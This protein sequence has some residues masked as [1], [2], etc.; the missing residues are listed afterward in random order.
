MARLE[1]RRTPR[2]AMLDG[3]R[4]RGAP[5]R[6]RGAGSWRERCGV[7]GSRAIEGVARV[8]ETHVEAAAK[9]HLRRAL[10]PLFLCRDPSDD[11]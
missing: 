7:A 9:L 11:P 5:L 10:L 4:W 2:L 6:A 1:A 3:G 8:D